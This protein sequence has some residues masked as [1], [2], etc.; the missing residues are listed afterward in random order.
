MICARLADA[1]LAA[2]SRRSGGAE[3][4]QL[5]ASGARSVCVEEADAAA[6]RA[7]LAAADFTDEELA[8]LSAR[9]TADPG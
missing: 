5:G 1:G 9:A 7:L 4:P 8:E 2:V 6:A 3:V